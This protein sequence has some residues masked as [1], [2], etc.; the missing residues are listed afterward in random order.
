MLCRAVDC[1][2]EISRRAADGLQRVYCSPRCQRE[3]IKSEQIYRIRRK[4]RLSNGS[5][6]PA[7]STILPESVDYI[8]RLIRRRERR[9][10]DWSWWLEHSWSQAVAEVDRQCDAYGFVLYYAPVPVKLAKPAEQKRRY[11]RRPRE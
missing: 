6:R 3:Q 7:V 9:E 11:T 2:V 1:L 4:T 10:T 8:A 5:I